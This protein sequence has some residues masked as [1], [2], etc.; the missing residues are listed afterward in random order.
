MNEPCKKHEDKLEELIECN[1]CEVY[2]YDYC[3]KRIAYH[4]K[5][6]LREYRKDVLRLI[7]SLGNTPMMTIHDKKLLKSWKIALNKHVKSIVI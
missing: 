1:N 6:A 3:D 7:E 4:M 5:T 2:S